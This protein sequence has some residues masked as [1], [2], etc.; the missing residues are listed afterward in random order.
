MSRMPPRSEA[1]YRLSLAEGFLEEARQDFTLGRWRACVDNSQLAVENAAKAVLA[2]LGPVGRT[3]NPAVLLRRALQ[4]GRF[5]GD[6]REPVEQ[7]TEY[8]RLLGPD[9]HAQSDYWDEGSWRLPD[10]HPPCGWHRLPQQ[11]VRLSSRSAAIDYY[12]P[13]PAFS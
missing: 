5:P 10:N 2:L 8:A 12:H 6:I 7:I 13:L 4:E 11:Q 1:E 9:V 3:H